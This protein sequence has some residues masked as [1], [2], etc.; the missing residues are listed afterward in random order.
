M[1]KTLM[2][3]HSKT[4]TR[5]HSMRMSCGMAGDPV[6]YIHSSASSRAYDNRKNHCDDNSGVD[7]KTDLWA[8]YSGKYMGWKFR[9]D[10]R[11]TEGRLE[12][13]KDG[14]RSRKSHKARIDDGLLVHW[15]NAKR[16]RYNQ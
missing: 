9:G 15:R 7:D 8:K 4:T 13:R 11:W 12:F 14:T 1:T 2:R 16:D 3:I 6:D 10:T 5:I